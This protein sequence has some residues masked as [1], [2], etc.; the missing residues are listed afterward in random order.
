VS[1]A[2]S[3]VIIVGDEEQLIPLVIPA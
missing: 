2:A 3:F 1:G